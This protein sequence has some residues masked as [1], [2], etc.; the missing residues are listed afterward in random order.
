MRKTL[1]LKQLDRTLAP[2][3]QAGSSLAARSGWILGVRKALGM[4]LAQLGTRLGIDPAGVSRYQDGEERGAVTLDTLRRTAD[5]LECDLVYAFVPRSGSFEQMVRDRARVVAERELAHVERTMAL[6][7]QA[8]DR[9]T[10]AWQLDRLTGR[11]ADELPS[12]LWD[13]DL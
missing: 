5:A 3:Y 7:D 4:T 11:L 9:E 8:V 1:S 13:N 10:S 6:E 2:F 12:R